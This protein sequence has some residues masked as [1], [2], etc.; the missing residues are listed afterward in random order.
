VPLP[1][2]IPLRR[3]LLTIYCLSFDM[4]DLASGM[5]EAPQYVPCLLRLQS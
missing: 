5:C 3:W 4:V 1:A 2:C